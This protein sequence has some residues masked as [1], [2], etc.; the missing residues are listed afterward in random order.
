MGTLTVWAPEA[1]SMAAVIADARLPMD[2]GEGGWWRI[3]DPRLDGEVDYAF[4]VD[5]G[6]PLPDPRSPRQP[7]GVHGFSRR[8]EH[9]A[10]PWTDDGWSPPPWPGAVL[11]ELHVGTFSPEGTFEGAIGKLDAL[12]ELG[13]THLQLMPVN[14]FPGV[15]GWGYDGVDLY[16]PH[17]PYG[18]PE[19]LKRLVDA[20]HRRGLAVLLDV[21]YNH[22]GPSGNYLERFGPY[23]TDRYHTPWGKAVNLDGPE[24]DEVRRF[25]C[26]NALM[27]LRDYRLDGLRLDAVH[28]I[29]DTSAVHIL[30]QLAAETG[31]LARELGR[32]KVLI[33]ESNLNDPR[34]VRPRERGGYGIDAQWSD[35]LHHALHV[36][37]TGE[38]TGY[39]CDFGGLADVAK[40]LTSAFVY[41]GRY[42]GFRRR[43]HGRPAGGLSG[44]RFLGYLQTHD[45]VG[46]RARGERIGHLAGSARQMAA[47]A[48][49]LLAPFVPMIFQGEEWGATAPFPY[50]TDHEDPALARAVREGRRREF[51]AFG[52]KPEEVPD[53]QDPATFGD[54]RLDWEERERGEHAAVLA[55]Y[56]GLLAL[57]A[58][59]PALRDGRM[60]AARVAV[61]PEANWLRMERGP[62]TVAAAFGPGSVRVPLDPGRPRT[63]LL[64]S[65]EGIAVDGTAVAL[66]GP[67]AV[68]LGRD[69]DRGPGPARPV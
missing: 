55:W 53:P 57:R 30:E 19:G 33:A 14:G 26:D 47:A 7:E 37:L 61:D 6:E 10:F 34:V 11:Y 18:G 38:R 3:E 8:V 42:S 1:R 35:D 40:A 4:S 49:V 46:N 41:D 22:L 66:P 23:F 52:W 69:G 64:A 65:R 31:A 68:V 50:F 48:V 43:R 54:A 56:R 36:A 27:W 9:G 16:A 67:G 62:V 59:V 32:P 58:R 63:V 51:A 2:S 13:V 60:A 39:Y 17:E 29:L 25:F 45:Q 12:R 20:A 21:V 24:S 44:E 15:H 28:A 5:G